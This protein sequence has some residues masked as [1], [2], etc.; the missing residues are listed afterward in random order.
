MSDKAYDAIVVGGGHHGLIISC[1]LQKAGM[2][3]A[4]F[5]RL[6]KL[7]GAVVSEEGPLPGFILNSCA[8]WTRFY[9][10][11]AYTDFNLRQKGLEY[12]FPDENEAIIFDND[13]CLVGYSAFRVVDHVTGKTEFSEQNARKTINEIARF[14]RQDADTA[15]EL[16][17]RYLV[18]WRAAFQ[19]YR[20]APPNPWGEKN[21]LEKLCDDPK[22][23]I[24]PVYQFMN[25]QQIA[26]DL[27]E[28]EEMRTFFIRASMTST[29]IA[30]DDVMGLYILIHTLG[31]VLSWEP[32]AIAIG[33][34]QSISN[35]LQ[36]AFTEMGG[37][38]FVNSEVTKLVIKDNK[39]VGIKLKDGAEIGAKELVVSDLSAY[40]T[41]CQLIGE[42]YVEPKIIRRVKN[43]R[44]DRHLVCWLNF[45]LHELPKYK[46]ACFNSDC[47]L[48][49][50]LYLT[51]RNADYMANKYNAEI[52]INGIASRLLPFMSIDSIWDKTRT[53]EGK[54]IVGIEEF[55]AP[56]RFFSASHW[57]NIRDEFARRMLQEWQIYAP[58]MTPDNVIA[59]R[60]FTPYDTYTRHINMHEG[61]ISCGDMI[62]SQQDRFRPIPELSGY[63]MPIKNLYLCSSAAHPGVGTSRGSSYCC[64]QVIAT[65]FGLKRFEGE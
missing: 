59:C 38:Y 43:I 15:E 9:G 19:K 23:G 28:S 51:P 25:C 24:D 26:Y 63:R 56:A 12:I 52:F 20:F 33:G 1:Y 21:E 3:T 65:N 31:M 41:I 8:N 22:D 16:L 36:R 50:R 57:E 53:P 42:D 54:H 34:S 61:S 6:P 27:F 44:Y 49:P 55:S 29:G 7:G 37:E 39:A 10:H 14:S 17:R 35:A 40:Q 18:K 11:P 48:Q 46:A 2:K 60:V 45:A 64:Y 47:G 4:I 32:A 58:N 5:E 62:A 13:S 30:P